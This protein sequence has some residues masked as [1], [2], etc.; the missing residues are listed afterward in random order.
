MVNRL[1]IPVK[2]NLSLADKL[3]PT[4]QVGTALKVAYC[5]CIAGPGATFRIEPLFRSLNHELPATRQ[6]WHHGCLFTPKLPG[7]AIILVVEA[8]VKL[9]T[10]RKQREV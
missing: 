9:T 8:I 4:F 5:G 6:R 2:F 10:S 7:D 3:S 1:P